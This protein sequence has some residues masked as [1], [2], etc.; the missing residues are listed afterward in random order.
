MKFNNDMHLPAYPLFIKDPYFSIWSMTDKLNDSNTKFWHGEE[1]RIFGYLYVDGKKYSFMG[2]DE[3]SIKLNQVELEVTA[4]RTIYHFKGDDFTFDVEFLSPL[5]LLDYNLLSTPVCYLSYNFISSTHHDVVVELIV[6]QE[7]CY[8]TCYENVSRECRANRFNLRD[9]ECVSVALERQ[10]PMSHS[11]DED[12]A[13]WGTYYLAGEKCNIEKNNGIIDLYA[14]NT[15]QNVSR[16][17]GFFMIG[18]DDIVSIFY[19]GEYLKGYY[20]QQGKSIFD[21]LN[22]SYHNLNIVREKCLIEENM[23]VDFVKGYDDKYLFIL[24]AAYRQA[25]GAHKL[26][27]NGKGD[28][29]FLSKESNSD[30]CIATVDVTYPSMPLFLLVQPELVKGMLIPIFDFA[31]FPIWDFDFA[32]HD[33]GIYPYCLGQY[34]AIINNEEEQLDL[35]VKDWHKATLLPFYYQFP[36]GTPI[37]DF[38][39]QMPVEESANMIILSYLY[40]SASKDLSII[41]DNFDLLSKWVNYLVE[42]GLR[43]LNQLCTDDFAGPISGNANL[44]IKAIEGINFYSLICKEL[45]YLDEYEKYKN[46]AKSYAKEWMEIYHRGDHSILAI[47]LEDSFSLKY[48]LAVDEFLDE[49]LFSKEFKESEIDYYLTKMNRYGVPLDSRKAYTKTD[50]LLWCTALT[51]DYT[52]RNK[53]IESIYTFLC[54]TTDKVPFTDWYNTDEPTYN[55]F[56]NRTVVG[57]LFMPILIEKWK[58]LCKK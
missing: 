38:N 2:L 42:K 47:D 52:K 44:A 23:V 4:L 46:I 17:D 18:F 11:N 22:E 50:W 14:I 10:L 5:T 33:A 30:G 43:P 12:A 58:E 8:N 1:K 48:N 25:I 55:M 53:I 13:D 57:G 29:L 19:Y 51:E 28:I 6:N 34:Y 27:K 9:F 37:F 40:S 21:A 56:R 32:P 41:K 49:P 31:R 45:N 35:M 54:E 3:E 7:I 24:N 26:V 39:K 36:K 20:F 16:V 15:H